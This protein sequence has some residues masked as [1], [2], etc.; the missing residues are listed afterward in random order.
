MID[1]DTLRFKANKHDPP[2]GDIVDGAGLRIALEMMPE[3]AREIIH[4]MRVAKA[5]KEWV[6]VKRKNNV[7]KCSAWELDGATRHLFAAVRGEPEAKA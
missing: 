7:G 1:I 3:H 2:Y 6:S 4:A 5:A